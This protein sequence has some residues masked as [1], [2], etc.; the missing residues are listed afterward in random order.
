MALLFFSLP[1]ALGNILCLEEIDMSLNPVCGIPYHLMKGRDMFHLLK[2]IREGVR[3]FQLEYCEGECED[4]LG[5]VGSSDEDEDISETEEIDG[6][7][8]EADSTEQ[9]MGENNENME[10]DKRD[11]GESETLGDFQNEASSIEQVVCDDNENKEWKS[12]DEVGWLK[13]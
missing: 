9:G 3:Q 6:I 1:R 12:T 11:I 2:Y 7:D 13:K 8:K 10:C 4:P 5:D